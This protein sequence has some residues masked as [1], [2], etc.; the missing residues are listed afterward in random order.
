MADTTGSTPGR[1]NT[2]QLLAVA[3]EVDPATTERRLE[4]WR[5]QGLLPH[6][7]RTAQQ[8]TRP[9]W[10]YPSHVADQLRALLRL[11]EATKDIDVLRVALWFDGYAVA[12]PVAR[13][14]MIGYLRKLRAFMERE[15]ERQGSR[16]DVDDGQAR[17]TA[18]EQVA[19]V[20]ARKR[21]K[22]LPRHG[23][24][25]QQQRERAV[26]TVLD[27]ALNESGGVE[28]LDEASAVQVEKL[29]GLTPGRTLRVG[30]ASPWLSGP[31]VDALTTFV[32]FGSIASLVEAA[33]STADADLEAARA[34]ARLL[35][36]GVS[37]AVRLADAFTGRPNVT[38]VTALVDLAQSPDMCIWIT[39]L[40]ASLGRS[41]A[42]ADSVAQI[43][44]ALAGLQPL[45]DQVNAIAA[46]SEQERAALL[47]GLSDLP[48]RQQAGVRRVVQEFQP[49]S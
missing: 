33:E 32:K 26:A 6:P 39:A 4:F 25:R 35:L 45:E 23:R 5:N 21:G 49:R 22:S 34:N 28:V 19:R 47:K 18:I 40:L 44:Q 27:I 8:G 46:M 14:A 42:H 9:V 11:R 38:G 31:A 24:Q 48:F 13:S 29:L 7:E 17:W 20:L 30:D 36:L 37:F 43:V 12:T 16:R 1:L 41:E 15:L 10:T 2:A 3:T